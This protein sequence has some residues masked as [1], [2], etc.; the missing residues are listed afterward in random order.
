MSVLLG[1][2]ALFTS[3]C[4]S[5][6]CCNFGQSA[7]EIKYFV[8]FST[9]DRIGYDSYGNSKGNNAIYDVKYFDG[10]ISEVIQCYSNQYLLDFRISATFCKHY[11]MKNGYLY[12]IAT[13]YENISKAKLIEIYDRLYEGR[14]IGN[15]YYNE[16]FTE[17][18]E[19]VLID[20]IA[21]TIKEP[22]DSKNLPREAM[23]I[24]NAIFEKERQI[25]EK[26]RALAF[27]KEIEDE[28]LQEKTLSIRKNVYSLYKYDKNSF[29][30]TKT[31]WIKEVANHISDA[32]IG[33][34]PQ[35][36]SVEVI[37]YEKK[38]DESISGTIDI[39][40]R[41]CDESGSE[42]NSDFQRFSGIYSQPV[43]RKTTLISG[44][45]RIKEIVHNMKIT[46]PSITIEGVSARSEF[47]L[48]KVPIS[49]TVGCNKIKVKDG[50]VRFRKECDEKIKSSLQ[51]SLMALKNG[52]YRIDYRIIDVSGE[53]NVILNKKRIISTGGLI[54]LFGGLTV[55]AS[56]TVGALIYY[57]L[58]IKE[59][60]NK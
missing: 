13:Q 47:S 38:N 53:K 36:P 26:E 33:I 51:P 34:A 27:Q 28:I 41:H 39:V 2:D 21:T 60:N 42:K 30:S 7:D 32:S 35:L 3:T 54:G 6:T 56:A 40:Y 23:A 55:G 20:G 5:Q 59:P 37:K 9:R 46:I 4:L 43:E 31:N 10:K 14:K 57:Q 49:Y 45:V 8:E 44:D 24:K 50:K 11:F 48:S 15:K 22:V 12:K 16:E 18:V 17:L 29:E 58:Y 25:K 52:K 19:I 1:A